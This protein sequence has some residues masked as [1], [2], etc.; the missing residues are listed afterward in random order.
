MNLDRNYLIDEL[1][2]N[3]SAK[4]ELTSQCFITIDDFCFNSFI[5]NDLKEI[6]LN[7]NNL[8]KINE[9]TF[10]GLLNLELLDLSQNS[11]EFIHPNAFNHLNHLKRLYLN[12]NAFK[13]ISKHVFTGLRLQELKLFDGIGILNEPLF[14]QLDNKQEQINT[15]NLIQILS[16]TDKKEMILNRDYLLQ[17]YSDMNT[18]FS[19]SE[20]KLYRYICSNRLIQ[21]DVNAFVGLFNLKC[22]LI[23]ARI[24]QI[25]PYS[26]SEL[27]YLVDLSLKGNRIQFIHSQTLEGLVNLKWLD[28]SENQIESLADNSFV[29]LTHLQRLDLYDNKLTY[30][31]EHTFN[32]LS[33]LEV[34]NLRKN[35]I[36]RI[37][38]NTFCF[39]R[40]LEYLLIDSNQIEHLNENVFD[41]LINLKALGLANNK[42]KS[43]H[44]NLFIH[45][46]GLVHLGIF[47]EFEINSFRF[48]F[49]CDS[50]N[51]IN[52][53]NFNSF[54]REAICLNEKYIHD[55]F[56]S[57]VYF[58]ILHFIL[59]TLIH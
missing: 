40:N 14:E 45:L 51:E 48:D 58:T 3:I 35:Q 36:Q 34:L 56:N 20:I 28:L 59:Q 8:T 18:L 47:N 11:I 50:I 1:N 29:C 15:R 5:F 39:M 7:K 57:P 53:N 31:T 12:K 27:K 13:S 54:I 44:K 16:D 6:Y 46:K 10:K 43:I 24:N 32:G 41:D 4:L 37:K 2:A 23:Q 42:F 9:N 52:V 49:E 30:L 21:I 25:D 55:Y 33:K 17:M 22:L 19:Q 38:A 26:F